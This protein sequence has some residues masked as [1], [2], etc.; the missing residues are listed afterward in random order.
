MAKPWFSRK[1][2]LSG[3]VTGWKR[4]GLSCQEFWLCLHQSHPEK[5]HHHLW[6]SGGSVRASL[7]LGF[8]QC[9]KENVCDI[10]ERLQDSALLQRFEYIDCL[11]AVTIHLFYSFSSGADTVIFERLCSGQEKVMRTTQDHLD[12]S[13]W[14]SNVIFGF[15]KESQMN[16]QILQHFSPLQVWLELNG[17]RRGGENLQ[18]WIL[19]KIGHCSRLHQMCLLYQAGSTALVDLNRDIGFPSPMFVDG[20]SFK[21]FLSSQISLSFLFLAVKVKCGLSLTTCQD[22][23]FHCS[24]MM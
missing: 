12:V 9:E 23:V 19:K 8:Q 20:Q 10:E 21:I 15:E 13:V 4:S 17:S 6:G 18:I 1:T 24:I 14:P 3:P 11:Q 22:H 5:H 7:H 2:R 16:R